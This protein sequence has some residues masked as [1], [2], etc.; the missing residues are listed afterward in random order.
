MY[1]EAIITDTSIKNELSKSKEIIKNDLNEF[2]E[3][4]DLEFD[5]FFNKGNV[6]QFSEKLYDYFIKIFE[7]SLISNTLNSVNG[8]QI[9]TSRLLGINRNTLRKKIIELEVEI[10]KRIKN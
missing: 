2:T 9:K 4:L 7:K 8:N 6:S 3:I 1:P 5:N 10:I